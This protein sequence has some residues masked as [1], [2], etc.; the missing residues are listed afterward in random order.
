MVSVNFVSRVLGA[1]AAIALSASVAYAG[2]GAGGGGGELLAL[3]C[4]NIYG[5]DQ[6]RS[7]NL[8]DQFGKQ[9]ESI[10]IGRGVLL[11]TPVTVTL[12][13][14][15]PEFDEPPLAGDHKKCYVIHEP[16][17]AKADVRITDQFDVEVLR[18]LTSRYLCLDADK[19]IVRQR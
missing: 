1:T 4:Y 5:A 8:T 13:A 19:G 18:V 17:F 12:P 10:R 9:Q 3:E 2:G 15:E 7:V 14:G 11:C 16:K 6:R